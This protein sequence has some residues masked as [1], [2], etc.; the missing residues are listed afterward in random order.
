MRGMKQ[1]IKLAVIVLLSVIYLGLS[2]DHIFSVQ[3]NLEKTSNLIKQ[4]LIDNPKSSNL[5]ERLS[6]RQTFEKTLENLN[7]GL[8]VEF[9]DEKKV[10]K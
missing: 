8:Q 6:Y 5:F 9:M 3:N 10:F 4:E 1:Q 2:F 7:P